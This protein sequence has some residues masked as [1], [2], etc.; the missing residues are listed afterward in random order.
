MTQSDGYRT[1][2][3]D[4]GYRQDQGYRREQGYGQGRGRGGY[5]AQRVHN[6]EPEYQPQDNHYEYELEEHFEGCN[7]DDVFYF[8]VDDDVQY[9]NT[10]DCHMAESD[11]TV[12]VQIRGQTIPLEIDTGPRCNVMSLNTVK[13]LGLQS[14]IQ[15][16]N[17]RINGVHGNVLQAFG[18][19]T[20]PCRTRAK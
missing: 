1:R 11:W 18:V 10:I 14:D 9:R 8:E 6:V 19:V 5:R 20:I 17:V 3:S 4:R 7:V 13:M 15:K 2:S 16:S 12:N